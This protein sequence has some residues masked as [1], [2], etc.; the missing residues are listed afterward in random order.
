MK[1][2]RILLQT[3]IVLSYSSYMT[4]DIIDTTERHVEDWVGHNQIA[5][6]LPKCIFVSNDSRAYG[7]WDSNHLKDLAASLIYTDKLMPVLQYTDEDMEKAFA[8]F[9]AAVDGIAYDYA[10][11]LESRYDA[12][13]K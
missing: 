9:H 8:E 2:V 10:I 1:R 5:K 12:F 13:Y 4:Y 11:F 3:L 6:I 7:K